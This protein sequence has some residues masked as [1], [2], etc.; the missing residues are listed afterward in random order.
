MPLDN[1]VVASKMM[2]KRDLVNN[3]GKLALKVGV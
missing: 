2:S 3:S 1:L